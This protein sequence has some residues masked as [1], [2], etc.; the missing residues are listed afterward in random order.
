MQFGKIE[1]TNSENPELKKTIRDY[2]DEKAFICHSKDH[3]LA[4][5]KING[6]W[7]NL[8]STNMLPPGPQII[9]SFYLQAFLESV[10]QN[11]YIIFVVRN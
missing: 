10:K 4:I 2:N 5:R 11:G 9:S 3:W 8:N 7:Y 1:I 6:I